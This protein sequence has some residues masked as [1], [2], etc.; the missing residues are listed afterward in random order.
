MADFTAGM[1]RHGAGRRTAE[2]I[3]DTIDAVGGALDAASDAE[4]TVVSCS[5]LASRADTCL[6]L[7]ADVL[8]RPT[9]PESEMG[10]IRDQVLA[11]LAGR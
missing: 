10:Q 3:A 2:Q 11:S 4:S 7:L 9:F 1:L 8:L 6:T 5:A